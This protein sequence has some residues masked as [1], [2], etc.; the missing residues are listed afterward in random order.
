MHSPRVLRWATALLLVGSL[1]GCS[2]DNPV[3]SLDND[4]A[5]VSP[6]TNVRAQGVLLQWDPSPDAD[7]VGYEVENDR[8]N[9][10]TPDNVT[11][12][13]VGTRTNSIMAYDMSSASADWMDTWYRVRA[14]DSD[15]NRSVPSNAVYV[16]T[17][18]TMDPT[19]PEAPP[20]ER[21]YTD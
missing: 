19:A 3:S 5:A 4:R 16:S 15:G 18:S 20:I 14:V 1:A 13:T 9:R 11:F 7:V 6:P 8:N 21:G 10:A 17:G 2:S 12:V